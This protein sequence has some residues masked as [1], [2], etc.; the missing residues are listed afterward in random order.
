[1]AAEELPRT[2]SV[3]TLVGGQVVHDAGVLG[4][5]AAAR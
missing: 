2:T 4:P 3:L 1:V 5:V